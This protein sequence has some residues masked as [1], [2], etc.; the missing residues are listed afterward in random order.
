MGYDHSKPLVSSTA[1]MISAL[2]HPDVVSD[3]LKQELLLDRMVVVPLAEIPY[4]HCHISPFG[5]IPNRAKPGKWR[6][7]VDLSSPGNASVNDGIDKQCVLCHNR[8]YRGRAPT[9]GS[10]G[11][12][13]KG[14]H[15]T[16]IPYCAS[17][18]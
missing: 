4:I 11:S 5:V 13:G 6:L 9:S 18:P 14:G 15:S 16:S 2:Q 7:T 3:Y 12:H 1:N 10:R 8:P 17:P